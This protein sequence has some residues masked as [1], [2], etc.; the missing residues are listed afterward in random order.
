MLRGGG[1]R[2]RG[3]VFGNAAA[4]AGLVTVIIVTTLGVT[5]IIVG[6]LGPGLGLGLDRGEGD[7]VQLWIVEVVLVG[8]DALLGVAGRV[9]AAELQLL[10]V[11]GVLLPALLLGL[12]RRRVTRDVR[13]A[14]EKIIDIIEHVYCCILVSCVYLAC[15]VWP[16][17]TEATDTETLVLVEPTGRLC[18]ESWS[19][20]SLA[21]LGGTETGLVLLL[22]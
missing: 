22:L 13:V 1:R 8:G 5:R 12:Q 20:V 17:L 10:A 15:G 7:G 11:H 14:R 4:R 6:L 9:L 3:V 18:T 19:S 2:G 21:S 16:E